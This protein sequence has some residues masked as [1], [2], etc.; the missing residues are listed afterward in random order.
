M[1]DLDHFITA[2]CFFIWFTNVVTIKLES[3]LKPLIDKTTLH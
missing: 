1:S 3:K 2:K